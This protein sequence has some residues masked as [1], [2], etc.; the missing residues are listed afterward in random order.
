MSAATTGGPCGDATTRLRQLSSAQPSKYQADENG[1]IPPKRDIEAL[2]V[3]PR[4]LQH[5]A[6]DVAH[7]PRRPHRHRMV[8]VAE[9]APCPADAPVQSARCADREPLDS[10]RQPLGGVGLA[11]QVDVVA[12]DREV[13]DAK[14]VL[15]A[16]AEERLRSDCDH[17]EPPQH[18]HRRDQA[19][20]DVHRRVAPQGGPSPVR[21]AEPGFLGRPAPVACRPRC[22]GG[23]SCCIPALPSGRRVRASGRH[24]LVSVLRP[25]SK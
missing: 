24:A 7:L 10:A 13:D 5:V 2:A 12:L 15:L 11:H 6:E 4:V 25:S 3:A 8:A 19:Q 17:L 14:A 20:G 1:S 22:A 23:S 18:P 21:H 9:H 16:A